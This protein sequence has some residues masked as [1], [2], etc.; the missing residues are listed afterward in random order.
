[1]QK[2]KLETC[3]RPAPR[4]DWE[5]RR[6]PTQPNMIESIV[7]KLQRCDPSLKEFDLVS[8]S[9]PI[10]TEVIRMLLNALDDDSSRSSPCVRK[11]KLSTDIMYDLLHYHD[12]TEEECHRLMAHSRRMI[13][14]SS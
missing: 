10:T 13:S 8:S 9:N 4:Q 11:L 2:V 12:A 7:R 14:C 1:M 3:I 6:L 5:H